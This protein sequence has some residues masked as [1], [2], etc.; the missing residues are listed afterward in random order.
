MFGL[1]EHAE[2]YIS[3]TGSHWMRYIS[4]LMMGIFQKQFA[5]QSW[6]KTVCFVP[7]SQYLTHF[8]KSGLHQT[9]LM[10]DILQNIAPVKDETKFDLHVCTHVSEVADHSAVYHIVNSS[11]H[12][13]LAPVRVTFNRL[14]FKL[15]KNVAISFASLSSALYSNTISM[16]H[17]QIQQL[18][19]IWIPLGQ[20]MCRK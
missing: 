17:P 5:K 12:I 10:F 14:I 16:V 8:S 4:L 6:K 9:R 3:F 2:F 15:L 7:T 13:W 11:N 19:S 1:P 20:L 18:H